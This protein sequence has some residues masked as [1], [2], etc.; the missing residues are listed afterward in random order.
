MVVIQDMEGPWLYSAHFIFIKES[1]GEA[2]HVIKSFWKFHIAHEN[3]VF[4]LQL[5][6]SS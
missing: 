5:K 6:A 1:S 4:S 3:I 2:N